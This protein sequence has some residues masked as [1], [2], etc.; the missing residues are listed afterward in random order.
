[1]S[2]DPSNATYPELYKKHCQLLSL[3]GKRPK[4]IEAYAR[5]IRRIGRYFEFH[6]TELNEAQLRAYFAQLNQTHSK[7][8]VKLDL[9]GLKFFYQYVL[10]RDWTD[11]PVI[12]SPRVVRI[13]D[14]V[15]IEEAQLLFAS[16]RILSYRVFFFT[17][18]SMGLRLSE[19][20]NLRVGDIDANHMRVHIRNSKGGK[21]RL[22][23]LPVS[24]L[25]VLRRFWKVHQ[26]PDLLFPNRKTLKENAHH[27]NT[28][29]DRGGVQKAMREVVK[30][31]GVKKILR[32]ILCVTV[33]PPT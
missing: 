18:Y 1:M 11:I 13:P 17:V 22:V 33:M 12:K 24:T 27:A 16:T 3:H 8:T 19:G 14:I 23:P 20:L 2:F 21:D 9:Y 6:L 10:E 25:R 32:Y 5:A 30:D 7:S 15:S 4:T 29:L 31:C 28:P 26:H